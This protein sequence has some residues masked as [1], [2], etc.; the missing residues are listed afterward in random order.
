MTVGR[1]RL[2]EQARKIRDREALAIERQARDAASRGRSAALLLSEGCRLVSMRQRYIGALGEHYS[3]QDLPSILVA[4]YLDELLLRAVHRVLESF[5]SKARRKPSR[6]GDEF[7]RRSLPA[8]VNELPTYPVG[9]AVL[10]VFRDSVEHFNEAVQHAEGLRVHDLERALIHN[11]LEIVERYVRTRD[12][13]VKRHFSDVEREYSA[14]GRLKCACGE[15]KY[16]LVMQYLHMPEGE[17]PYDQLDLRCTACGA[18]RTITF[19]LPY[20]TDMY[21]L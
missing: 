16:R 9:F 14:V 11:L 6:G 2:P 20:F 19:D 13:A 15:E 3:L 8:G 4:D 5:V 18:S 17:T 1:F 10:Y 7:V 21:Q 12:T